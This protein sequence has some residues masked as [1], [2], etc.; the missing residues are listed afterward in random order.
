MSFHGIPKEYFAAGDPYFCEC[1]K[2]G[3]LLAEAL[4]LP[5]QRWQ[6]TFQSRLGPKEWLQPY[7]D[8]T[9]TVL[10]KGGV[11]RVHVICPGFS[12]DCLETLEEIAIENRNT[13]LEA[14]GEHYGYIPCLNADA[15]HIEMLARL[16]LRHVRGWAPKLDPA[17]QQ[18]TLLAREKRALEMRAEQ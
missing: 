7:T 6:L 5:E 2:T 13:F 8:E 4:N 18:T 1:Q 9:F 16:V 11:R 3:R 10:A 15:S 17:E 14:G 12:A